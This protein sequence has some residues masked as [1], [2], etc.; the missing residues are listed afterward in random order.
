MSYKNAVV[1][2]LIIYLAGR[3]VIM[4]CKQKVGVGLQYVKAYLPKLVR[5]LVSRRDYLVDAAAEIL[6][7]LQSL[8][9]YALRQS[10]DGIAVER[11]LYRLQSVYQSGIALKAL[12][13]I[14]QSVEEDTDKN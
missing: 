7:I 1:F 14:D 13:N 8:C 12:L 6:S 11:I 9:R 10:V 3:S 5:I 4:L 2:E